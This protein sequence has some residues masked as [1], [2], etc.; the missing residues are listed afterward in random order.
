MVYVLTALVLV[1]IYVL[2]GLDLVRQV[3]EGRAR[4][5]EEAKRRARALRRLW[6]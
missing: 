5:R 6:P 1:A 3:R 4:K 2:V